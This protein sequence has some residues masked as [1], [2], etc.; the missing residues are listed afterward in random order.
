VKKREADLEAVVRAIQVFAL[1]KNKLL[2][3]D[4][5]RTAMN[6]L[7]AKVEEVAGNQIMERS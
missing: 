2:D 5:V 4:R 1:S 3:S 6:S 7:M